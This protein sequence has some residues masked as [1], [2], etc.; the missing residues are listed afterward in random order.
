MNT[1]DYLNKKHHL[2]TK[3]KA[4]YSFSN[5]SKSPNPYRSQYP[6]EKRP[7]R[8]IYAYR[9]IKSTFKRMVSL[10]KSK[11]DTYISPNIGVAKRKQALQMKRDHGYLWGGRTY[12][13]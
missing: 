13:K 10:V 2:I 12:I 8:A 3:T 4:S 5:T 7:S 1:Q 6:T 11:R 9:A